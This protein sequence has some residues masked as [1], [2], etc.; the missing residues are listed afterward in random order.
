[1]K[2]QF[3][4][5]DWALK[6]L[7]RS[8]ANFVILEGFLSELLCEDIRIQSVL[9]SESNEEHEEDTTNR[10]DL[11]VKNQKR[12]LII[13]GVQCDYEMNYL[14]RILY[15]VSK[16]I[17]ENILYGLSYTNVKKVIMVSIVYCDFDLGKDY[18]Y[19]GTTKFIGRYSHDELK[20]SDSQRKPYE[21]Y[22]ILKINQ[23]N[24]VVKNGLDEWIYFLK[25]GEVRKGSAAKGLNEAATELDMV[26]LS[27]DEQQGF[28]CYH[29]RFKVSS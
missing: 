2:R 24:D 21:E 20:F 19:H 12:E 14:L 3:V 5:F 23:F 4:S 26:K 27:K 11:L 7:L 17:T 25:N 15:G 13:I 6:K 29:E 22:Y 8:K 9:E 1:M 10:V 18:V 16:I 28:E